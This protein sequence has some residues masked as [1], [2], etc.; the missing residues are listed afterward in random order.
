MIASIV[1]V[2]NNWCIGNNNELPWKQKADLQYFRTTTKGSVVI[3]GRKTYESIGRPL[4]KRR[5]I[6]I[7]RQ[8]DY[9][10][11][12]IEVCHSLQEAIATATSDDIAQPVF[13]IGGAQIYAQSMPLIDRLY[14]TYINT[15]V[16]GDAFFP[17]VDLSQWQEVSR[18]SHPADEDNQYSYDFVIFEKIP[19]SN[20]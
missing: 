8:Q 10:A 5:N 16:D 18:I 13:I 14:V 15:V 3:M 1:A 2:A 20:V 17:E 12:G 6:I 9:S 4:P 7:T 19:S 11:P